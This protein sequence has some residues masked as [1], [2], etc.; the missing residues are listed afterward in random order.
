MCR[1]FKVYKTL[2]TFT[3]IFLQK[4]FI[5][6]CFNLADASKEITLNWFL[7]WTLTL[8]R[9]HLYRPHKRRGNA[10]KKA[11]LQGNGLQS[12]KRVKIGEDNSPNDR[13]GNILSRRVSGFNSCLQV[14]F[15]VSS[16]GHLF[17]Q[18]T[19]FWGFTYFIGFDL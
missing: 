15:R 2:I 6:N 9:I 18:F 14:D 11:Q 17:S 7:W 16:F 1:C 8:T 10:Q 5:F 19:M 3:W 4:S 12:L 13:Y